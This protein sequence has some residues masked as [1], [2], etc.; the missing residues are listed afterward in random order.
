MTLRAPGDRTGSPSSAVGAAP[1][2]RRYL[3][4]LAAEL[5]AEYHDLGMSP[6]A[7]LLR[8]VHDPVEFGDAFAA[9]EAASSELAAE[10]GAEFIPARA[11]RSMEEFWRDADAQA[12]GESLN[13]YWDSYE[14]G[15]RRQ[16][17]RVL[18]EAFGAEQVVLV[19]AGM[20]ALD[21][22]LRCSGLTPGQR[23][24]AHDRM[25]FE[26]RDLLDELYAPWGVRV[27]RVDM[28]DHVAVTEAVRAHRPALALVEPAL[29]GPGCDVPVIEPLMELRVRTV[30]DVSALGHGLSPGE[31]A[32]GS[33]VL[34]VESGMKYL[35]RSAGVG[36]IYG[37][38]AW[39]DAARQCARQTGQQLQGRALHWLR[40][41]EMRTCRERLA[42]HSARR[43][44]FV[45]TLGAAMPDLWISDARTGAADRDDAVARAV[46]D[47]ADGCMVFVRLP[48]VP[49]TDPE[50]L[51]RT[52][53]ARW[54]AD[55]EI[56]RVRAGF[57]WTRTTGR[58][59]GR[60]ALNSAP[61]ECFIRISVGIE[62]QQ[63][64]DV[65]ALRLARAAEQT[66]GEAPT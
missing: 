25:Y 34:Y 8:A 10:L 24:L 52:T 50:D 36:V 22:A 15:H 57:G 5:A 40:R 51:H 64:I 29:N 45:A 19:N 20:S 54:A 30:I 4:A 62:P 21:V 39:A 14:N 16:A 47:G 33:D 65:L 42:V 49:G 23:I 66:I 58:A 27:V 41:G 28:R 2:G 46:R 13:A 12:A 18:A 59:Y 1:D 55:D 32:G 44:G 56:P 6:P 38:S 43:R 11:Y 26:S 53:V 60:D 7:R 35:T 63:E 61:A 17:E 48:E 31:L 3:D 37:W 9:Y